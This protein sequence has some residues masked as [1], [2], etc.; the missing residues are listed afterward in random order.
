MTLAATTPARSSVAPGT[1][2][3][4]FYSGIAIAMAATVLI[5]FGPTFYLRPFIDPPATVSGA[6]TL[7]PLAY[8]H[9]AVFTAWVV[10]FIVQTRLIA[11]RQTRVHQRLGIATAVLGA[12]MVIVGAMT[13]IASAARGASPP[14]TDPLEFLV[15]PMFDLV[16]FSAFLALA[17]ARR[18]DRETHKRLMLMAYISIITAAIARFPGVFPLGPFGFF[19]LSCIFI[20]A[21]IAY[22]LVSRRRVHPVYI[23]GGA[24]FVL[25][26]P[27]R[28]MMSTTGAWRALAEFLTR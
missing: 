25:S 27:L 21:G 14:G 7:S 4:T 16:L 13:A 28:L 1:S 12:V 19:G 10:L 3:R 15:V 11:R 2:D 22:D 17:V 26:V 24:A 20:V 18:R 9:G 23:W 6:R 5:G 8:L